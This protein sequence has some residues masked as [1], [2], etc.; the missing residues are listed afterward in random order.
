LSLARTIEEERRIPK[1]RAVDR[2]NFI[3]HPRVDEIIALKGG[4]ADREYNVFERFP[5]QIRL[6][7]GRD[8]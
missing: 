5:G 6:I 2:C 1:A 7:F 3:K 4:P 8:P